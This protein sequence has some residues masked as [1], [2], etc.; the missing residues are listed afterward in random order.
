LYA[1]DIR[2]SNACNSLIKFADDTALIGL[3]TNNDDTDY[4]DDI[5]RFVKYCDDNFLVLNVKKT[6]E[7]V[8]DFRKKKMLVPNAVVIKEVE[9]ER[10][11][12]YK[13]LGVVLDNKL[14]FENHIRYAG[15]PVVLYFLYCSVFLKMSCIF[16]S[17]PVCP[18]FFLLM[19][20]IFEICPTKIHT[21]MQ[22]FL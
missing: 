21:H 7:M 15:I 11:N 1:A 10:V 3:I 13:Y 2:S 17:C 4:L 5:R 19:S 8:I 18:V 16:C 14:K 9:V 20:Y 12:E 22:M 6:Q